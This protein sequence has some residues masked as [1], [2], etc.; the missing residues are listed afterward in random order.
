[1]FLEDD[2]N[3]PKNAKIGQI[4]LKLLSISLELVHSLNFFQLA[5]S[6]HPK[7][8]NLFSNQDSIS[9][10]KITSQCYKI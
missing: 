2:S 6:S 10:F 7:K 3:A 9:S 4:H 8:L 1:M 5:S